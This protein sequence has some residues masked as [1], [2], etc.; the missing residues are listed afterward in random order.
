MSIYLYVIYDDVWNR[1]ILTLTTTHFHINNRLLMLTTWIFTTLPELVLKIYISV[2]Y[3]CSLVSFSFSK[4]FLFY[5]FFVEILS[6][7]FH[8][9]LSRTIDAT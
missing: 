6:E 9:F 1:H 7:F 8:W 4:V 5:V 3:Y 2:R